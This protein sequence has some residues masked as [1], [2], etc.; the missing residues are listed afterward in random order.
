MISDYFAKIKS[1]IDDYSHIVEYYELKEKVYG[2]ESGFIEGAVSFID[3]SRLDFAEVKDINQ[4]AKIK[5]HYHFMDAKNAMFF[6]Y[7]N[8][9]HHK[10]VKTF[11]HHKHLPDTIAAC[12]EPEMSN[13]LSEIE[14]IILKSKA[15][16]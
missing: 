5:Y 16:T 6:R 11:P 15:I 9:K 14:V 4:K 13:I 3:A 7:D 12:A 2:E 10:G 8:A 1:C